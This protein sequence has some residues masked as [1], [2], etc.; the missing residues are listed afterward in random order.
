MKTLLRLDSSVRL[1]GS[2]TRTLTSYYETAW[3][4][5]NPAGEVI[6][7]CLVR[8]DIPHLTDEILN[9]FVTPYT[10]DND[11]SLSNQ[12]ISELKKA[13]HL[14]IGSPLYNLSLP[15]SLKAYF[16]H[17]VRST[18]TFEVKDGHY[19]G[20]LRNIS[21]TIITARSGASSANHDDDYQTSYLKAVLNFM[22]VVNIDI[23]AVECTGFDDEE[24]QNS[25]LDAK[26]KIDES[27]SCDNEPEWL[28]SFSD[29]DKQEISYLRTAQSKAIIDGDAARY[30]ELC[31]DDIQL[32]I[33]LYDVISGIESFLK[34]EQT[35]FSNIKFDN[36][37]KHPLKVERSGNIAIEIGRQKVQ[38]K[39]TND[40]KGVFSSIQ[41]YTHVFRKT[42]N[43]WRL[44]ILMSNQS[45]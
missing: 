35:V 6:R 7:R 3:L 34:T 10:N 14:V 17:V 22:G 24:I 44:A 39:N 21:A 12:L 32:L 1:S 31:T 27:F 25:M 18:A 30:A 37:I 42:D 15:S 2:N 36:F 11:D 8:D 23:I 9:D 45:E 33:P 5:K 28:G 20:L 38:M 13:D 40:N 29:S 26:Q 16:D 41:K 19:S 43:G 4:N